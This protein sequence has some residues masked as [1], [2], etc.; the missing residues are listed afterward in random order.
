MVEGIKGIAH[1]KNCKI[2]ERS[3][4][5]SEETIW[6]GDVLQRD[7]IVEGRRTM[8]QKT[9]WQGDSTLQE[10][11]SQKNCTVAGLYI[12]SKGIKQERQYIVKE[13]LEKELYSERRIKQGGLQC[14]RTIQSGDYIVGRLQYE[15]FEVGRLIEGNCTEK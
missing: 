2:H 4:K 6:Q 7:Y 8:R 5:Q 14:R 13:S 1:R 15:D 9:V 3:P 10:L 12:Y 11:Y